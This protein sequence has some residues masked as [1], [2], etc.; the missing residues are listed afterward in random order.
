MQ[1][2]IARMVLLLEVYINKLTTNI[3]RH[4]V[5]EGRH[6]NLI[7]NLLILAQN[8][9]ICQYPLLACQTDL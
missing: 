9:L 4:C 8:E 5:K 6:F 1:H 3:N 2:L 7:T